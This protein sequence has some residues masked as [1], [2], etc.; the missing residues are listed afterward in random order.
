MRYVK[1][2][3]Y[4]KIAVYSHRYD[5]DQYGTT[6]LGGVYCASFNHRLCWDYCSFNWTQY[7]EMVIGHDTSSDVPESFLS[8][9]SHKIFEWESSQSHL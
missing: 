8:S 1:L 6:R 7:V 4:V 3:S 2:A 5:R 9:Q